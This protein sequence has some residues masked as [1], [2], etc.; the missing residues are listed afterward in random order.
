ML[1]VIAGALFLY[2][3]LMIARDDWAFRI[4]PDRFLLL[5]VATGAAYALLSSDEGTIDILSGLAYRAAIPGLLGLAA[6]ALYRV[7]RGRDGLG[8][9]DVKLMAAAG[10][11]LP[12]LESF[13]AITVASVAALAVV[14]AAGAWRGKATELTQSLPFA[15]FLGPA[16]WLLWIVQEA[17]A[18][19]H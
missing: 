11:W 8:L 17:E 15:V 18:L 6:A 2:C 12:L 1:T 9:G 5:L 19:Y 10:I 16:F 13:H 3:V 7:L 14:I 4:V